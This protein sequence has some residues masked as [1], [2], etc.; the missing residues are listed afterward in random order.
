MEQL[1]TET[2]CQRAALEL[3]ALLKHQ[4]KPS[5]RVRRNST[6]LRTCVMQALAAISN[7]TGELRQ[8]PWRV[9]TRPLKRRGRGGLP[10]IPR[11]RMGTRW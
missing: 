6:L 1:P 11:L 7:A 4:R 8:G 9:G 10:F 2:Y 3:A 5:G